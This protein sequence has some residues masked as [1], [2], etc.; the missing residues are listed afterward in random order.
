MSS[1]GPDSR[2]RFGPYGG[3]Y[4]PETLVV[5]LLG[6]HFE[7]LKHRDAGRDHGGELS[8]KDGE[9]LIFNS[10]PGRSLAPEDLFFRESRPAPAL[11][12]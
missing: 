10:D 11:F 4:V 2:G 9:V 3:Q 8:C 5:C 12:I 7:R 6:K 1:D